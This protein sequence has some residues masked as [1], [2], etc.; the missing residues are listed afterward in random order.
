MFLKLDG[1]GEFSDFGNPKMEK[2]A[3]VQEAATTVPVPLH[4]SL[5]SPNT[6]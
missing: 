6:S 4:D 2:A 5:Q 1:L 3:L